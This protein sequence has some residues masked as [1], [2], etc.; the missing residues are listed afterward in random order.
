VYSG[1][2]RGA[3]RADLDRIVNDRL[4]HA[5]RF[6]QASR[7]RNGASVRTNIQHRLPENGAAEAAARPVS[8]ESSRKTREMIL[9]GALAEFSEKGST[10]RA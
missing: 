4:T 1:A 5:R 7:L 6:P 3:A 2:E 8:R 10:A 9:D